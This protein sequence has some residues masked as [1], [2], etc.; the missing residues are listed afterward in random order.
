MNKSGLSP[1]PKITCSF[2]DDRH[3]T[4]EFHCPCGESVSHTIDLSRGGEIVGACCKSSLVYLC[5]ECLDEI[6]AQVRKEIKTPQERE[7]LEAAE[8]FI[9]NTCDP[10]SYQALLTEIRKLKKQK[11]GK[12]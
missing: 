4:I 10:V 11:E 2:P 8:I 12:Q 5:P 3:E 7:V 6:L 9:L 1:R